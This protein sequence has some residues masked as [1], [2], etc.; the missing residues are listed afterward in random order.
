MS[1]RA[2]GSLIADVVVV[3]G[4]PNSPKMVVK[5]V[6]EE[7]KLVTAVW[8]SDDHAAQEAVF[9]AQALDRAEVKTA[10]SKAAGKAVG[11][12]AAGRGR[13]PAAKK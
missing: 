13:K 7:A 6:A 11:G 10:A 4:L 3:S 12:A 8:F 1:V 9:P 2:T 5:A